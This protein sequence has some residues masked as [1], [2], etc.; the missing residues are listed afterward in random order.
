MVSEALADV[1]SALAKLPRAELTR[2]ATRVAQ[3]KRGYERF[4]ATAVTEAEVSTRL[5]ERR[6]EWT[7]VAGSRLSFELEG[8]ARETRLRVVHDG[9]TLAQVAGTLGR[10]PLHR[11][12]ELGTA[13]SEFSS[14]LLAARMGDL[15]GPWYEDNRWRVFEIADRV[16]PEGSSDGHVRARD[17]LVSEL[18]ERL[19]VGKVGLLAA[20]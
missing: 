16:E 8:A 6:L 1:P 18:L 5:A 3:L 2:R 15:I 13:P 17:E 9:A 11:E 19:A 20:L 4:W 10:K 12:L 14:D 7:S